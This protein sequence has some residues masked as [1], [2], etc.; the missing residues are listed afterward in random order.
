MATVRCTVSNCKYWGSGNNCQADQILVMAPAS[1][2]Q[3][4]EKHGMRAET[5]NQT[6]VR[7]AEDTLCY[8][9]EQRS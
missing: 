6:P 7:V 5:L 2:L 3:Q 8:T 9:F 1:P 4:A